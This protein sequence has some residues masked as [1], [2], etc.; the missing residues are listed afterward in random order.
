MPTYILTETDDGKLVRIPLKDA[1][2][3][4][5]AQAQRKQQQRPQTSGEQGTALRDRSLPNE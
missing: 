2:K 4:E 5:R 1:P 3:W